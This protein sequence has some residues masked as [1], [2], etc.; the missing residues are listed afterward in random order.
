MRIFWWDCYRVLSWHANDED[1]RGSGNGKWKEETLCQQEARHATPTYAIRGM[2]LFVSFLH[3]IPGFIFF[4]IL[5]FH[6]RA[7]ETNGTLVWLLIFQ[8]LVN[9]L[10]YTESARLV[11]IKCAINSCQ[12]TELTKHFD[13]NYEILLYNRE[14]VGQDVEVSDVHHCLIIWVRNMWLSYDNNYR[15]EM[16]SEWNDCAEAANGRLKSFV[17]R[18]QTSTSSAFKVRI[19]TKICRRHKLK[20]LKRR[21]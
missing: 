14:F 13:W 12:Q 3:W 7:N 1:W 18:K 2:F 8:F 10:I 20:P 21:F 6:K 16:C 11:H 4:V 15:W 9:S 5:W 17:W 19:C